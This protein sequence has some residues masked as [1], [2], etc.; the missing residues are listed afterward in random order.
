MKEKIRAKNNRT[1]F[2]KDSE[3]SS[4]KK[5]LLSV[6]EINNNFYQ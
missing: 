6:K 4:F 2:V 1:T 5:K 3:M